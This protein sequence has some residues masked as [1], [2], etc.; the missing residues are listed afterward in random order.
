MLAC[1]PWL[2]AFAVS[3][4]SAVAVIRSPGVFAIVATDALVFEAILLTIAAPIAGAWIASSS[5]GSV[6]ATVRG[7][8]L[9][10]SAFVG[11]SCLLG[12]GASWRVR[13]ISSS[14]CKAGSLSP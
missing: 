1:A 12:L 10:L 7:L 2:A 13:S 9:S 6:G 14:C 4:H 3:R 11:A 5:D 8:V